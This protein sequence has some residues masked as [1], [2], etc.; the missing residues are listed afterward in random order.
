MIPGLTGKKKMSKSDPDAAIFM[1]D[2]FE[3]IKRKIEKARCPPFKEE[4]KEEKLEEEKKKID[5]D[6]GEID[7]NLNP[8]L[9][10][11]KYIIM[12]AFEQVEVKGK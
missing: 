11:F 7:P 6:L 10:Y 9:E 3:E 4:K 1:E 8:C 2:P 5:L 12:E